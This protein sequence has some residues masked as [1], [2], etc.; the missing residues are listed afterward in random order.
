MQSES[1]KQSFMGTWS[2]SAAVVCLAL[3]LGFAST[4]YGDV[5]LGNWESADS[6]NGWV[7][8]SDDAGAILIPAC[9]NGV[10]L[11]SGSLRL[12]PSVSGYWVLKWAGSPLDFTDASLQFDVTMRAADWPE[13][14]WTCV[15]D[16]IAINSDVNQVD[17][18]IGTGGGWKEYDKLATVI[19]RDTGEPSTRD[20]DATW[21][22]DVNKTYTLDVANYNSVGA[23]WMQ[24][25]VSI[26]GGDGAASFYFDNFRLLTPDMTISKCKVTAGKTQY[27][28]DADYNDMKDAFTASGIVT[29]PTVYSD[30]NQVV[31]TLTSLADDEVIYT[32]TLTDFNATDVN[33]AGKYKHSAKA[34]KGHEGNITSMTLDFRKGTFALAAKNIDLTGLACPFELKFTLGSNELKGNAYEAAVNGAK[35]IPTRLMRL[36]DDKLVVTKA[37][38]KN[39][40]KASSDTLSVTGEIAVADMGDDVNEPNLAAEDVN[41]TWGDGDGNDQAFTIPAGSFKVAKKGNIYKCSKINVDPGNAADVND[42]IVAATIDLDKGTFTLSVKNASGIFADKAGAAVFGVN[43]ET[44]NGDFN[45]VDDYTLP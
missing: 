6:N 36:Y 41:F 32:E 22:G 20:W 1:K 9:P 24:I 17:G 2:S 8:G 27:H 40:T 30:V 4:G 11:G 34:I 39:S 42:G 43:F 25:I 23:T 15:A 35:T 18:T 5:I 26:Q 13:E 31:V 28:G 16:K 29:L 7:P 21:D 10:T 38:A 33:H 12:I 14:P 3:M 19:N 44:S 37:K 45:E